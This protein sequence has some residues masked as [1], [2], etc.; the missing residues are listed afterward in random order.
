MDVAFWNALAS[1]IST[2]VETQ[3]PNH[4]PCKVRVNYRIRNLELLAFVG[5]LSDGSCSAFISELEMK[6]YV[7]LGHGPS[8][9]ASNWGVL[10]EPPSG[11]DWVDCIEYEALAMI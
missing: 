6:G 3:Q 4:I 5:R 1:G 10:V 11:E 2:Y 9:S 7:V 8:K